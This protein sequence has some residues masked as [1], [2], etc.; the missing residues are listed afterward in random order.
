VLLRVVLAVEQVIRTC[1]RLLNIVVLLLYLRAASL[2]FYNASLVGLL[3]S[4]WSGLGR[5]PTIR[6]LVR[7]VFILHDR[8]S[9]V[10]RYDVSRVLLSI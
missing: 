1:V 5:G 4:L 6:I 3:S 8:I 10:D 9:I 7:V 2:E